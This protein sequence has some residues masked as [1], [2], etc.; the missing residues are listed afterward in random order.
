MTG[1]V[2]KI[3]QT[4]A[5]FGKRIDDCVTAIDDIRNGKFEPRPDDFRCPRCPYLF[6]C[7]VPEAQV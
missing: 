3:E 5:K 7:A 6:I 2:L 1:T 4:T